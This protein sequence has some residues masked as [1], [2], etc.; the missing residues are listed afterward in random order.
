MSK[1][2]SEEM[3]EFRTQL[4]QLDGVAQELDYLRRKVFEADEFA[5]DGL[6][7]ELEDT[8]YELERIITEIQ[9]SEGWI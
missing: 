8:L 5:D 6:L 7:D 3:S 1:N 2:I 4:S 9:E